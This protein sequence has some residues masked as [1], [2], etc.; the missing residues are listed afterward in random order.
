MLADVREEIEKTKH[1]LGELEQSAT[2]IQGK[3]NERE[4]FPE[5]AASTQN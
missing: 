3:I 5:C 4:A 2:I 1:R